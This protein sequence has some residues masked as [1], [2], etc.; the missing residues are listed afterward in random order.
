MCAHACVKCSK[1]KE[2]YLC[3]FQSRKEVI[4]VSSAG[5][6]WEKGKLDFGEEAQ[7]RRD[8]LKRTALGSRGLL[9]LTA[10]GSPLRAGWENLEKHEKGSSMQEGGISPS[11]LFSVGSESPRNS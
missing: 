5:K 11:W 10:G 1:H 2:Q 4:G 9:E 6:R 3:E 8:R 7:E